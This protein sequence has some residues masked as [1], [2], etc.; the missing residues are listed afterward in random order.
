MRKLKRWMFGVCAY[1]QVSDTHSPLRNE[2]V[3]LDTGGELKIRLYSVTAT[4]FYATGISACVI[5]L[6]P[7][8]ALLNARRWLPRLEMVLTMSTAHEP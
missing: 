1:P 6:F 4:P 5:Q 3:I 8:P 2:K 7:T